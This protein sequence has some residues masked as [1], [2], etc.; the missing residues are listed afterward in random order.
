MNDEELKNA[1][2]RNIGYY[3]RQSGLTQTE[4]GEKLGYT[5]KSVSKWERGDGM[6]DVFVLNRMA[7]LW[8]ISPGDL[9]R[10][11]LPKRKKQVSLLVSLLSVGL[12]WLVAVTV[13]FALMLLCPRLTHGWLVFIYAL[14]LSCI[15]AL[16]FSCLR[17]S[18]LLRCLFT[19]GIVWGVALSVHLTL[20]MTVNPRGAY[21]LYII[22]GVLQILVIL[23]Y[24][25]RYKKKNK[26]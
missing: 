26:A 2:A 14:P 1:I 4:L 23:W 11:D 21:M 20:A 3:R 10:E 19:S 16:V 17:K 8:H 5:D 7:Q 15:V 18:I 12:V 6:P 22:A 13:F 9:F 25:L 24:L